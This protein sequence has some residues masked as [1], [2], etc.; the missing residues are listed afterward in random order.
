MLNRAIPPAPVPLKDLVLPAPTKYS[1]QPNLPLFVFQDGMQQV[2]QLTFT[3]QKG[4]MHTR[5]AKVLPYF[6]AKTLTQGTATKSKEQIAN[7]IDQYGASLEAVTDRD[8]I[9][10]RLT[11]LPKFFHQLLPLFAEI[12]ENPSFPQDA[13]ALEKKM[14]LQSIQLR[15]ATPQALA[16]KKLSSQAFGEKHPY[17][18]AI[19]ETD[20]EMI[21]TEAFHT[22][23]ATHAWHKGYCTLSGHVDASIIEATQNALTTLPQAALKAPSYQAHTSTTPLHIKKPKAVQASIVMGKPTITR[24]HK[25]FPAF[26]VVNMLLGGY[27]GARLMQNIREEKGYTYGIGSRLIP[28]LYGGYFYISTEVKKGFA[29]KTC[30]EIYRE[31]KRLKDTLVSKQELHDLKDYLSGHLLTSFDNVFTLANKFGDLYLHGLDFNYYNT[32]Y[33]KIQTIEP[34]EI[35]QIALRYLV[36]DAFAQV[37]V[38]Q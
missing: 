23:F 30:E 13:L 17:G 9:H 37:I 1:I 38:N 21:T 27:F 24:T 29:T 2:V 26:Y 22:Y 20:L 31:I 15:D 18:C 5:L 14:A 32:L 10:V 4:A 19:E 34:S 11:V 35:Q 33:K 7:Y 12:V 8:T 36:P 16:K 25:D 3:A 28:N 6:L